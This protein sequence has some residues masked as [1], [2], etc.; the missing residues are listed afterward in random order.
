M[1]TVIFHFQSTYLLIPIHFC[2]VSVILLSHTPFIFLHPPTLIIY[3][4]TFSDLAA[5][6]C[7]VMADQ[8]VKI[9]DYGTADVLFKVKSDTLYCIV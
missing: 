2:F 8:T 9:G 4:Q 3:P 7:V 5:R 6:N 1:E